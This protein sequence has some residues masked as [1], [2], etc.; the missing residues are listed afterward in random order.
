M[1]RFAD[2]RTILAPRRLLPGL[3]A[4]AVAA[5]LAVVIEISLAALIF[6][7]PLAS[8]VGTGI[9]FL[10]FGGGVFALVGALTSSY[11]GTVS[12]AQDS[13]AAIAAVLAAAMLQRMPPS[14]PPEARFA[15]VVTAI[16][17]TTILTGVV[18]L[19]LGAFKLGGL[20]RYIPY[21]VVGG[22]L[23]GTGWMLVRGALGVMVDVPLDVNHVPE[24]FAG[25]MLLR[26]VP[27]ILFALLL[28][29][30]LRR[31]SH[32]LVIPVALLAGAAAF[33]V[34]LAFTGTSLAEAEIQGWLLGPFPEGSLWQPLT[35]SLLSQVDWRAILP[36]VGSA[37]TIVIISAIS[38]LLNDSGLE[39]TVH[40]DL[41]LDHELRSAGVAN[42]IAGLGGSSAGYPALSLSALGYRLGA[43][44]RLVGLLVALG[45]GLVLVIGAPLIAVVP[46][47]LLGGI[48]GLLGFAFLIE[49]LYD[50][51]FRLSKLD[52]ALIWLILLVMGFLGVLEGV[53]L[54]LV[55]AVILFVVEYSRSPV[56]RHTLSGAT[57]HSTVER[58]SLER[59]LIQAKGDWIYILELQ[60]FLFF[61][62]GH[63]L[64][65]QIEE[66]LNAP[67]LPTPHFIVLDF[68]QVTGVDASA[69]LSLNKLQQKA[70]AKE[71]VVLFT[72]L[73]PELERAL[74]RE[75]LTAD[76]S[77]CWRIFPDLDHGVEWCE[78]QL[79]T[80]FAEVGLV[81]KARSARR[82][83]DSAS[84]QDG[85]LRRLRDF[86]ESEAPAA[87]P[88]V[89]TTLD[90]LV[91]LGDYWERRTVDAGEVLLQ[92]GEPVP[93]LFYLESGTATMQAEHGASRAVRLR[94][95][96][97]GT[98]AGEIG[99]ATDAP[100]PSSVVMETPGV[101]YYL[102]RAQIRRLEEVDPAS[103]LAFHRFIARFLG[104]RL[105]DASRSIEALLQ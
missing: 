105:S 39:L 14:V 53:G 102:S 31:S 103:A 56:A 100:S 19:V 10:L 8:H 24:L 6:S 12:V 17:L 91:A 68:R 13:P 75:V 81:S 63:K 82:K 90:E 73:N 57:Y 47:V 16:A 5:L 3:T 74:R 93:G 26:W 77:S 99:L 30:T 28:L 36:Q 98:V 64:L 59:Q 43:T 33:Y 50:T 32:F 83:L 95:I 97:P 38:L 94:K 88:G 101:V 27:G 15:T 34:T 78:E 76:T 67:D 54:G 46:R 49:W 4:G 58:P 96:G 92:Q 7:G 66:R 61:G 65:K 89:A 23:A 11:P 52:Y 84:L 37:A 70:Q 45:C 35:P 60:G 9:G 87:A 79:L 48:I 22:F 69:L 62:T 55:L 44:S 51:W 85:A 1:S 18:L 40:R 42:V 72:H 2:L 71:C 21:P 41:D 25:G 86:M 80:V 20:V 104:E 29:F